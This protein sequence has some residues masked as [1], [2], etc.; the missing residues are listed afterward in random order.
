MAKIIGIDL[1][2]TN[3]CMGLMEDNRLLV[4]PN[5][6][7]F[8][9]TPSVVAF[10]K[11][12]QILVGNA[13]KRQ[14]VMNPEN[15]IFSVKRFI[16]RKFNDPTVSNDLRL[17]PYKLI[18]A[19]NGDVWVE[20]MG[21]TYSPPELSAM[22]LMKMK[23]DAEN[24]LGETVDKAVVTV[25]AHFNDS[26]RQATKDAGK[27]AGLE[28][29]R[30]INEPTAA[31]LASGF[32]SKT[33]MKV[34]IYDLGGGTFDVSILELG[35][36]IF[37]VLSTSGDTHLGGDDFDQA[38]ID[39]LVA[40]F[41]KKEGIDLKNDRVAL[42]RLKDAA[43][44]AKINLSTLDSVEITLPF[45]AA[46]N[47][48]PKHLQ[49]VL[50]RPTLEAIT[51]T[52]AEKTA[53]PCET[54][55]N[56]AGLRSNEIDEIVLV[57]GQTKMPLVREVVKRIFRKDPFS[58]VNPDE[59]VAS[60]AAKQASVLKG[61]IRDILLLDVTAFSLGI[62]TEGGIFSK[63]VEKNSSIPLR[64]TEVYTTTQENQ[65]FVR[66]EVF[67]GEKPMASDNKMI[68][69]FD[70]VGIPPGPKGSAKI[71]VIFD[72][73]ANGIIRVSAKDQSTGKEQAIKITADSG[74][75]KAELENKTKEIGAEFAKKIS[76]GEKIQ[77]KQDYKEVP[78]QEG[79]GGGLASAPEEEGEAKKKKSIF[80]IFKK[81]E[82]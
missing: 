42:Q 65:S 72:I 15:T 11:E 3:S 2:T 79:E 7:N 46:T 10:T 33:K 67:Q 63:I 47:D 75:S 44:K 19:A 74:L 30:I 45:L 60:G 64:K 1:G 29:V 49:T 66:I 40:E 20:V 9:T 18:R 58:G 51:K 38:I 80:D 34:V 81:K 27:I 70:L 21:K 4:I 71:D 5:D 54:A 56:D 77:A 73:D 69:T 62:K 13:A 41:H 16:G 82:G 24:Y 28:I 55:L 39:Y 50:S 25:P 23:K 8:R 59:A 32:D 76:R 37:K 61:D 48:G 31:A 68:G 52:I 78:A 14:Q 6:E 17:M 43:E 53:G 57:G 36:G 22:I 26:Q 12:G 35:Q